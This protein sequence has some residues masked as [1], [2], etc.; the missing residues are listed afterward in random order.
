MNRVDKKL[1]THDN[2]QSTNSHQLHF[3]VM[4]VWNLLIVPFHRRSFDN[5]LVNESHTLNGSNRIRNVRPSE[6]QSKSTPSH[7]CFRA[8]RILMEF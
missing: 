3:V 8:N 4:N 2:G 5:R 6:F 7:T 1:S